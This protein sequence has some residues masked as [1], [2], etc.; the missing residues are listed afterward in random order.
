MSQTST[1]VLSL[2]QFEAVR[3]CDIDGLDQ[4]EA[5][6]KMGISRG[7]V[8]RLL[9][10]ARKCIAEAILRNEAIVINLKESEACYASLHTDQRKR[11][12]GRHRQ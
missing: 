10:S 3:L 2:D 1:T 6:K 9:Y 5:G 8:Q 7:T 4:T 11:G 12:S